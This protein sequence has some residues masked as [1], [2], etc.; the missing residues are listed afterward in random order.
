MTILDWILLIL[1][2]IIV[3]PVL[4]YLCIKWGAVGFYRGKE[5]Y[6]KRIDITTINNKKRKH[7]KF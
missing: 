3:L 2:L 5:A 1:G 4:F 6:K 7:E